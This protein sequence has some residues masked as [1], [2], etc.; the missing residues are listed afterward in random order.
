MI[1]DK[2]PTSALASKARAH[3]GAQRACLPTSVS[4]VRCQDD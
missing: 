3:E 4:Q 1:E 2:V